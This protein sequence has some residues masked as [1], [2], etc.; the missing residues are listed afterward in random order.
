MVWIVIIGIKK[1]TRD[2]GKAVEPVSLLIQ[3]A[4]KN[5]VQIHQI[6]SLLFEQG[7]LRL[8]GEK[9]S[10]DLPDRCCTCT[11]QLYQQVLYQFVH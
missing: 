11:T 10:S 3:Q 1:T 6:V 9:L 7:D 4:R 5:R 8:K 2:R